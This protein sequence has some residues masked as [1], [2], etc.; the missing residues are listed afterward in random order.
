[1]ELNPRQLLQ[2]LCSSYI[3]LLLFDSELPSQYPVEGLLLFYLCNPLFLQE[4]GLSTSGMSPHQRENPK[5]KQ[6]SVRNRLSR[7]VEYIT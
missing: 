7:T 5:N 4:P 6:V 3:L 1:M 2:L